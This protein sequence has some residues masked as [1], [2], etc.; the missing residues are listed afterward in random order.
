MRRLWAAMAAKV[1]TNSSK[2]SVVHESLIYYTICMERQT[3][4]SSKFKV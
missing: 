1:K 4:K 3:L 2:D